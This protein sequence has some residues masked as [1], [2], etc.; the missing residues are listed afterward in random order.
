M[1]AVSNIAE[2]RV[3]QGRRSKRSDLIRSD[4]LEGS[5]ANWE[6]AK[7]YGVS[8]AAITHHRNRITG[9]AKTRGRLKAFE[10]ER[11]IE[12]RGE[13]CVLITRRNDEILFDAS[14]LA[15]VSE[16]KV[17]VQVGYYNNIS[18][19]CKVGAKHHKLARAL[20]NADVESVVDHINGNP[21]D[22][23]RSNLRLCSRAENARNRAANDRWMGS[24]YKG[25]TVYKDRWKAKITHD[26][27]KCDLGCYENEEDAARAYDKMALLLHREFARLN[28]PEN[29]GVSALAK[30]CAA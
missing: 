16:H 2:L 23:R 20:L 26:G 21:L 9:K 17:G 3:N 8:T 29:D 11:R 24:K 27:I 4:I 1:N 19:V 10:T 5:L 28:F 22:N 25:V 14:D 12:A 7:K 15:F 30:E 18:V 13:H 6:I